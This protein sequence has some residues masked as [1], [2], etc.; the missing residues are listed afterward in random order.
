MAEPTFL[1]SHELYEIASK[2]QDRYRYE[3]GHVDLDLIFF[4]EKLGAKGKKAKVVDISGINS[5][6]L[7]QLLSKAGKNNKLYCLSAWGQEWGQYTP[8]QKHWFVFDCLYSIA[9]E[10]NGKLRKPDVVG[11]GPI[12][13]LL[14]PYWTASNVLPDMLS[15][16]AVA[17][18]PP[19]EPEEDVNSIGSTV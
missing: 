13:E 5:P 3:L 2:L 15:G 18:P 6:W 16:D 7:K 1:E 12:I 19:P 8:A 10:N 14:G 17:I 4:A 9:P 11:H